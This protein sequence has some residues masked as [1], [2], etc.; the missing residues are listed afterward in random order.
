MRGRVCVRVCSINMWG[1]P[2]SKRDTSGFVHN[3]QRFQAHGG[4]LGV[5]CTGPGVGFDDPGG[6]FPTQHTL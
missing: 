2:D 4:I 5:S 1:V 6:S 3:L